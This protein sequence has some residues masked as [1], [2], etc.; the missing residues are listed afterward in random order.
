MIT[1][2]F[3]VGLSGSLL[4]TWAEQKQAS[5]TKKDDEGGIFGNP[6]PKSPFSKIEIGMSPSRVHELI[7]PPTDTIHYPT[8]K[9]FIPFYH[10]SDSWR[11][12]DLY[13]GQ[14]RITYTGRGEQSVY[15]VAYDPEEKGYNDSKKK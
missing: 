13:K 8:G 3:L 2:F 7:G 10:G 15:R 4:G 9:Q 5:D 11:T 1:A 6:P 14:G 12:E